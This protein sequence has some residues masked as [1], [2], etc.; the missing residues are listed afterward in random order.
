MGLRSRAHQLSSKVFYLDFRERHGVRPT[1]L[2]TFHADFDPRVTGHGGWLG[3][4][5]HMKDLDQQ[6]AEVVRR[7]GAFF[8]SLSVTQMSRSYKMLLLK[9]MIAENSLPGEVSL[10]R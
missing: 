6:E 3:F 8:Q 2:E 5:A 1:A 7:H 4:V 9:A 10:D